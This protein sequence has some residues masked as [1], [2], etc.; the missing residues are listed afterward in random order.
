MTPFTPAPVKPPVTHEQLLALDLRV[1]TIRSVLDVPRSDR[2]V[3]LV[4]DFGDHQRRIV[5]GIKTERADPRELEGRQA[6]FAVNVEPR[7]IRGERSE[8]MLFDVGHADG[9]PPVLAVPEKPVP[10]G[11]RAG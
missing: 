6:L 8:G 1:G 4:V 3:V 11:T 7:T 9:I 2:L 10:D 5:A